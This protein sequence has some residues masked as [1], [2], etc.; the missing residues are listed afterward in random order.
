MLHDAGLEAPEEVLVWFEWH[1]GSGIIGQALPNMAPATL[2]SAIA[3]H[4]Q[5]SSMVLSGEEDPEPYWAYAGPGWLRLG[6]DNLN[7]AVD[8]RSATTPVRLRQPS[9]DFDSS[10]GRGQAVSLCTWIAWRIAGLRAG[11]YGRFQPEFRLW[12]FHPELLSQSQLLAD[13]S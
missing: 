8:C 2:E 6:I 1:N 10:T 7:V 9:F 12:E 5:V 11:A 4:H 3:I 13:F